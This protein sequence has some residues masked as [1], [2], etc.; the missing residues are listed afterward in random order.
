[1]ML[2]P[3]PGKAQLQPCS[4]CWQHHQPCL[5]MSCGPRCHGIAPV[6]D[7]CPVHHHTLS[8]C[9]VFWRSVWGLAF[10]EVREMQAEVSRAFYSRLPG[11]EEV[12]GPPARRAPTKAALCGREMR[13]N[14]C[15]DESRPIKIAINKPASSATEK[16][17]CQ[18]H[19]K[20]Y[21]L[22]LKAKELQQ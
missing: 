18:E 9:L 11:Q 14:L 12:L 5:L 19:I 17:L 16:L 15:P 13:H 1:M 6:P 8:C 21:M 7:M 3:A 4:S 20:L 10:R 2:T 22:F